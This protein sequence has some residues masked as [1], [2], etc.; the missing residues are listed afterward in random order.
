MSHWDL[1]SDSYWVLKLSDLHWVF[2]RVFRWV[3]HWVSHWVF[4]WALKLSDLHWDRESDS[5]WVFRW[6][7][8]SVSRYLLDAKAACEDLS[9][10]D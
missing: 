4:R 6:A 8:L 7:Q 5:H 9:F 1:E 2:R 10:D 3:S